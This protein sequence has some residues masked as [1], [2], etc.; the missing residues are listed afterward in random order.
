MSDKLADSLV[1]AKG[2]SEVAVQYASPIADILL[3]ERGVEPIGVARG[4]DVG[5]WCAL[6]KNLLNGI[7]GNEVDEKEDDADDEPDDW[8]RVEG[9]LEEGFQ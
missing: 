5:G 9:A 3:A 1:V 6:A 4:G 8:Q 7:S 2:V